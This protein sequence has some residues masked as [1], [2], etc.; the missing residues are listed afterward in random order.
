MWDQ[1]VCVSRFGPSQ[2]SCSKVFKL[3][4]PLWWVD[5]G[6]LLLRVRI[7]TVWALSAPLETRGRWKIDL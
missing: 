7:P 3:G 6:V 4:R 1:N 2:D 5:P